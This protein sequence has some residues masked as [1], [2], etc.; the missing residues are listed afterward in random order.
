LGIGRTIAS[1]GE[2]NEHCAQSHTKP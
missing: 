1:H 2:C